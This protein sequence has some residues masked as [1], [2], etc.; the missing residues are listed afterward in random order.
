M[1]NNIVKEFVQN[2]VRKK[3]VAERSEKSNKE[4]EGNG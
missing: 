2:P 4:V 3:R 1:E